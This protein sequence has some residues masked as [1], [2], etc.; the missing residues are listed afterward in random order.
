M[1]W[2]EGALTAKIAELIKRDYLTINC[3]A[4]SY[5]HPT[6]RL[7][8]HDAPRTLS[9]GRYCSIGDGVEIWVG[10]DGRHQIDTLSSYPIGMA[11]TPEILAGPDARHGHPERYQPTTRNTG[12][13]LNVSIGHDVWIGAQSVILAGITI[14]TGAI[15][16]TR[17]VV[18]R[19]VPPYGIAVGVPAKVTRYRHDPHVIDELLASEWWLLDPDVVWQRL[20]SLIDSTRVSD[21]IDLLKQPAT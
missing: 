10:A 17:A 8:A 21:V 7:A 20:G 9:I 2:P 14:G 13:N 19:D 5:G 4:W 1:A 3:G 15:I 12:G 16:G 11:V 18:T 6:L